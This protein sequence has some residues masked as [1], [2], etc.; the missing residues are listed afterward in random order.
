MEQDLLDRFLRYVRVDTAA[1][2]EADDYPSSPGQLELGRMLVAELRSLGVADA[3]IDDHGIVTAT[4]PATVPDAP[5]I[6]WVAHMDTS[7]EASGAGVEPIVHRDYPGGDIALPGDPSKVIRVEDS[8]VLGKLVGT[9]I[10]TSDGTTLLGADDKAGVAVI[11][12]A[13]AR[14][15][16]DPRI[17]HGRVRIVFTCDEE[18]GRG[19]DHLPPE[20]VGAVVAYTL[21]GGCEG[22]IETETFSA[23]LAV[24]TVGGRNIHPGLATG[25]MVNALRIASRFVDRMPWKER[26]PETTSGRQGFMHPYVLE[27]GVAS[28]RIKI[29]LRSFETDELARYAA[30]LGRI[31]DDL[32]AEHPGSAIDVEVTK[33]YR[34]LADGL[35]SEPRAVALAEEAMRRAGVEPITRATRGGTDGSRL[36]ELGL[37][38]PNLFVGMQNFHSELEYASLDHMEKAVHVLIEL[39]GLWAK[40]KA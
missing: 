8:P 38:T 26:A 2:D 34:N 35:A 21:D 3:A 28:A 6:A 13:A 1:V 25:R 14:L 32:A 29:L 5:A 11:M 17:E 9:T 33:Q 18:I 16:A 23:D 40:E 27:A 19:V 37:P 31:A 30:E 36:T 15:M 22:C 39:A 10:V 20:K 24:V 7:P 4:V 12:T